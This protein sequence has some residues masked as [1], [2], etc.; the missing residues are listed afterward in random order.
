MR[1]VIDTGVLVS[2]LI[3]RQSV[4]GDVLQD[5]SDSVDPLAGLPG[6]PGAGGGGLPRSQRR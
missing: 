4:P 1:A 2:A 5:S 3:R 6:E